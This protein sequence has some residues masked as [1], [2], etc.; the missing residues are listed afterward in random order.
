M[1]GEQRHLAD[2]TQIETERVERRLDAEIEL[3]RR[4]LD[5][6]V[7]R[8]RLLLEGERLVLLAFDQLHRVV[9][10]IRREV[11][12]LLLRELDVLEGGSDLVERQK[13]LFLPLFDKFLEL[14]NLRERNIDREQWTSLS[15]TRLTDVPP[16][17]RS[18]EPPLAPAP[19]PT[20]A[21][22]YTR[23]SKLDKGR[24]KGGHLARRA[25]PAAADLC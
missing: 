17:A 24:T 3:R 18:A 23:T 11:L 4:D 16:T 13:T 21:E 25:P 8:G 2:L 10:Q 15:P 9:A 5:F 1:R 20:G 12:D 7:R 22:L 19:D 14:L 6:L